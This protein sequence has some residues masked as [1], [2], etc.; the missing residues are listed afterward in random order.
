VIASALDLTDRFVLHLFSMRSDIP[1]DENT[2]LSRWP[3]VEVRFRCHVCARHDDVR[4]A[5][6]AAKKGHRITMGIL[7][8]Q[9]ASLCPWH[10]SNPERPKPQ[11]YGHRCGGYCPDLRKWTPPDMPP[12]MGG[13]VVVEGGKGD[14]LPAEPRREERRRRVGG[15]E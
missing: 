12:T 14:I 8:S 4:L 2:P 1:P 11:K 6:L 9:W 10:H 5:A 7:V 15:D 13:L 3:W